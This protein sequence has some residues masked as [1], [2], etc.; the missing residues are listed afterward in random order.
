MV[1]LTAGGEQAAWQRNRTELSPP[2]PM[3]TGK[4][5]MAELFSLFPYP[6]V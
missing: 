3:I 6:I 2:P 5:V 1:P 4:D